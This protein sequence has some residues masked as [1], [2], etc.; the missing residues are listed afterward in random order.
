M[1][2]EGKTYGT[3]SEYEMKLIDQLGVM[4]GLRNDLDDLIISPDYDNL[5][6]EVRDSLDEYRLGVKLAIESCSR[7][8]LLEMSERLGI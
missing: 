8:K 5:D 2:R 4:T 3:I 1:C 6:P 7:L